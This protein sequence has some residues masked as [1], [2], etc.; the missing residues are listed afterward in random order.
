M[1]PATFEIEYQSDSPELTDEIKEKAEKR[2]QKLARGR[3]DVTGAA[4]A[5]STTSGGNGPREYRVRIVVYQRAGNVAAVEK[6]DT[7]ASAMLE[8]VDA[9][10]RQVREGREKRRRG[11]K[12]PS[13]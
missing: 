9:A 1:E 12:K 13:A 10:E 3:R 4:I 5:V 11:W 8:A 6:G 2:L 7:V